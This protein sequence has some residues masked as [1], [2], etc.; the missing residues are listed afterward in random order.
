MTYF[1]FASAHKK[2]SDYE[3]SRF[4]TKVDQTFAN[5]C[6]FSRTRDPKKSKIQK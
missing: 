2:K 3:F 5:Q 4:A 1:E 6:L